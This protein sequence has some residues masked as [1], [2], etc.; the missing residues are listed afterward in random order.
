MQPKKNNR[1]GTH[2][3]YVLD[4]NVLRDYVAAVYDQYGIRLSLAQ[5]T[6]S[7]G[8]LVL[9]RK[10]SKRRKN[11]VIQMCRKLNFIRLRRKYNLVKII[12][13]L[14]LI[15]NRASCDKD[16]IKIIKIEEK[17]PIIITDNANS[18]NIRRSKINIK[19]IK[20]RRCTIFKV[21]HLQTNSYKT[22]SQTQ[23]TATRYATKSSIQNK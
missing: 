4:N 22:K 18:C 7:S 12:T 21:R 2:D 5:T 17:L 8:S 9:R 3:F 23:R 13:D 16:N 10:T 14:H 1:I 20:N 19:K 11:I 15:E 6:N